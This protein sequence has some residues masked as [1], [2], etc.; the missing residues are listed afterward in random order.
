MKQ[1]LPLR[2]AFGAVAITVCQIAIQGADLRSG[3]EAYVASHQRALVTELVELLT[4]PNV[5]ADE[6]NIRPNAVHLRG[7]LQK[8][9]LSVD[10]RMRT[11]ALGSSLR[12]FPRLP[13][14]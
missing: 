13:P 7:R 1:Y 10:A 14:C 8:R 2:L 11:C 12:P 4:I 9:G 3:V 6:E 5:S